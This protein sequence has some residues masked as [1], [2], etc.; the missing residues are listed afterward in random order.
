M[1]QKTDSGFIQIYT[2]TDANSVHLAKALLDS[3]GITS[4]IEGEVLNQ[5]MIG[6]QG[7]TWV[8]LMVPIGEAERARD[9]LREASFKPDEAEDFEDYEAQTVAQKKRKMTVILLLILVILGLLA[10]YT[11]LVQP[12]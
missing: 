9:L 1:H 2:S 8:K 5:V 7:L 10:L 4:T 12:Q 3:E 6:Y 11:Y